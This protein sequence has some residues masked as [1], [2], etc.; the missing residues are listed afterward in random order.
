MHCEARVAAKHFEKEKALD[1]YNQTFEC[2][3]KH[4]GTDR[5]EMMVKF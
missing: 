1:F 4:F 2:S 3:V 5:P